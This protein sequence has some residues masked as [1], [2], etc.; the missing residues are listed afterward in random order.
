MPASRSL[1]LARWSRCAIAS[2]DTRNARA[3]SRVETPP[4]ARSVSATRDSGASAGWQQA[5]ISSS[6]SSGIVL[7]ELLATERLESRE[8][9]IG[10]RALALLAA[11]PVDR[12]PPRGQRDP[13]RRV[14]RHAVA[15]PALERDD[16][17]I[18]DRLF[19]AVEV[20]E[21]TRQGGDRLSGL[22]PEQAVDDYPGSAQSATPRPR[23]ACA[24]SSRPI[25]S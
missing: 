12:A 13:R 21:R 22:A 14:R 7:I 3:T 16:E 11:Q 5:K 17:R 15:R 23:S 2:S 8:R 10:E 25:A 9:G 1:R 4:S 20:A 24:A 18:L 6:R 19:G